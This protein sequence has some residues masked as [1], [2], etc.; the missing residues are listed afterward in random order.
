[1]LCASLRPGYE[2]DGIQRCTLNPCL[3][4]GACGI[5]AECNNRNG[6]AD[7]QCPPQ[8]EG[9]PYRRCTLNPCA[10]DVCGENADCEAQGSSARCSC[11]PGQ[12][13]RFSCYRPS[14]W[15]PFWN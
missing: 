14:L 13:V 1:M 8:Y 12:S 15:R 5:N 7:C 3:D 11:R 2:G 4:P 6:R 10:G 9:D